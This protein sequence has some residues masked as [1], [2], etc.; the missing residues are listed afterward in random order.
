MQTTCSRTDSDCLI[1]SAGESDENIWDEFA[2]ASG[3]NPLNRFFWKRVLEK[4]YGVRTDFSL[5]AGA[6]GRLSGILAAYTIRDWKGVPA[7]F[8]IRHGLAGDSR[9]RQ[10]LIARFVAEASSSAARRVLVASVEKTEC[11]LSE[12]IRKTIELRLGSDEQA[13]WMSLKDKTRNLIRKAEKNSVSIA[14]GTG[15]LDAFYRIYVSVMRGNGVI[16]HSR[17]FFRSL[18]VE[19]AGRA[20]LIVALKAGVVLGGMV[21]VKGVTRAVYPFQASVREG[22]K[23]AANQFLIWEAMKECAR[24]GISVLDMGESREQDEVYSFKINFGGVPSD[25][26]YYSLPGSSAAVVKNR[27]EAPSGRVSW[28]GACVNTLVSRCPLGLLELALPLLKTRD[29]VI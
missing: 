7:F 10:A 5:C 20:E 17:R 21:L 2:D 6:D 4:A 28:K 1:R 29:R 25:I 24:K 11:G 3:V 16:P 13:V 26:F 15:Y 27:G 23:L 18:F 19:S 9:S 14:R 8:S 22:M 12:H